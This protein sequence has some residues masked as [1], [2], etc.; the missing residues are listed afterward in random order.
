MSRQSRFIKMI[1]MNSIPNEWQLQEAKNK[2]SHLVKEAKKGVPQYITVHGKSTAVVIS[3][4]E[5]ERL[6]RPRSSLSSALLMPIL[7]DPDNLFDR[8]TDT[9]RDIN[10]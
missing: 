5:Y 1:V 7:D 8:S 2:L 6:R 4:A 10:L 3:A 9:G